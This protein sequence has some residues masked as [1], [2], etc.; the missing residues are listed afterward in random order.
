M[1]QML[2]MWA[3]VLIVALSLLADVAIVKLDPRI[4]ARGRAIG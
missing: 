1:V 3:A 2:S 4:R